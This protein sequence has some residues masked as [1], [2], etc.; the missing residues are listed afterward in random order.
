M[1]SNYIRLKSIF[2]LVM[3]IIAQFKG[4][5]YA[6]NYGLKPSP[7]EQVL[8]DNRIGRTVDMY[9]QAHDKHNIGKI[10]IIEDLHCNK[11]AQKNIKK[12]LEY[13]NAKE[14]NIDFIGI[15]GS[16]GIIESSI[17]KKIKDLKLRQ[18]IIDNLLDEGY[19]TGAELYEIENKN[20]KL[21][22]LEDE[23]LY[24]ENFK[25]LYETLEYRKRA[26]QIINKVTR[27][28]SIV[29]PILLKGNKQLK[30]LEIRKNLYKTGKISL[31]D[32]IKY[33][34]KFCPDIPETAAEYLSLCRLERSINIEQ[35][36]LEARHLINKLKVVLTKQEI[37]TL[38]NNRNT[39][40]YYRYLEEILNRRRIKYLH[41]YQKLAK[42]ME[43]KRRQAKLDKVKLLHETDKLELQSY[44]SLAEFKDIKD[45]IYME[46]HVILLKKY[47]NNEL[48]GENIEEFQ[49]GIDKFNERVKDLGGRISSKNYLE[50]NKVFIEEV[51]GR[52]KKFYKGAEKR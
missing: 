22:G 18:K 14:K 30:A 3:F 37:E 40:L 12:I 50:E 26:D 36:N 28:I 2:V 9:Q 39:G 23:T 35:V 11:Q 52:I 10:Y 19:L 13:I 6:D 25:D 21:Y 16:S 33:L 20:V 44:N 48:S 34:S 4:V 27:D 49:A 45:L 42:Y 46:R 7:Y 41:I 29:K 1:F 15:E 32:Y 47:I 38:K 17:I 24:I 31:E 5:I 51:L 43:Y 8:L